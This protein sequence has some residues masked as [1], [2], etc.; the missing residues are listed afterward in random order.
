VNKRFYAQVWVYVIATTIFAFASCSDA[1]SYWPSG[2]LEVS[3][4]YEGTSGG[5]KSCTITIKVSN[6]GLS[7]ISAST[8]SVTVVTGARTYRKTG[9]YEIMILPNESV[10]TTININYA[11]STETASQASI[12]NE[13]YR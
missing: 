13:F 6:I 1:S 3:Y 10:Y 12:S 11:D 8:V 5:I 7:T 4:W 2:R 9:V